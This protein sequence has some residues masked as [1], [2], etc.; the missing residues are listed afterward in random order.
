V[1]VVGA[2]AT[3]SIFSRSRT[4]RALDTAAPD[5]RSRV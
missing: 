2:F 5:A 1:R 4:S 3:S